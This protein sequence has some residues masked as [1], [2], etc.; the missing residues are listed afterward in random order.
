MNSFFAIIIYATITAYTPS[1]QECDSTPLITA[2]NTK[3]KT[4]IVALSR[5]IEKKY[6]LKFGD[7]IQIEGHGFYVFQDRMNKKVKNTIDVFMWSRKKAIKF[8]RKH[9]Q[10]VLLL[11]R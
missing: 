11:R 8:G 9:K 1:I 7:Y 5:D 2:S 10:K 3:V 6:R 4:G